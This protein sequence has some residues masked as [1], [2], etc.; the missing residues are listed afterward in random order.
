MTGPCSVDSWGEAQAGAGPQLAQR[1]SLAP[2]PARGSESETEFI[3]MGAIPTSRHFEFTETKWIHSQTLSHC[4]SLGTGRQG[5]HL[6]I[7]QDSPASRV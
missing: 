5:S 2:A 4:V 6:Q 7:R 1:L 3:L